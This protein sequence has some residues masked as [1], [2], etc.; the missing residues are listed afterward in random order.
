VA[1]IPKARHVEMSWTR[2]LGGHLQALHTLA[3][4]PQRL[5]ERARKGAERAELVD[6]TDQRRRGAAVELTVSCRRMFGVG[7]RRIDYGLQRNDAAGVGF[8]NRGD[9]VDDPVLHLAGEVRP[10]ASVAAIVVRDVRVVRP[11]VVAL[12]QATERQRIGGSAPAGFRTTENARGLPCS[13]PLVVSFD[14]HVAGL[15]QMTK[16][17]SGKVRFDPVA[18][19]QQGAARTRSSGADARPK[20]HRTSAPSV[21]TSTRSAPPAFHSTTTRSTARRCGN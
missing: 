5:T 13:E 1:R 6:V 14:A 4:E 10:F 20:R 12:T 18:Q 7:Q 16:V 11:G 19:L 8:G 17:G 2:T 3:D 9:Q 21:A 15:Q